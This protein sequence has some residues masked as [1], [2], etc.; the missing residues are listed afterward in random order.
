MPKQN[1]T[2]KIKKISSGN[3]KSL[4]KKSASGKTSTTILTHTKKEE[5]IHDLKAKQIEIDIQKQELLQQRDLLEISRDKYADLYD[6][7]PVG[8]LTLDDRG[9]ITEANLTA[10]AMLGVERRFL[11]KIPFINFLQTSGMKRF[12]DTL[13]SCR[14]HNSRMFDEF[15]IN[16][17]KNGSLEVQITALPVVDYS[18]KKVT[19]RLS[20]LDIAEKKKAQVE[21]TESEERFRLMADAAP[22]MIWM[23]D[24]NKK[25]VYLNK[26]ST[27][28]YGKSLYYLKSEGWYQQTHP[29]D[30]DKFEKAFSEASEFNTSRSFEVRRKNKEG[31]YR[32][33]FNSVNPRYLANGTFEGYAG[34]GF[35]ITDR[36][37]IQEEIET[38]LKEKEILLTEV[39][40]RVKN[41]LQIISSILS[42][43]TYYLG[44]KSIKEILSACR[45]RVSSMSLLHEQLYHTKDFLNINFKSY[46]MLLIEEL[47]S[48]YKNPSSNIDF[49]LDI[50]DIKLDIDISVNLGLI[51]NE[52]ITNSLK[53]A[54]NDKKNGEINVSIKHGDKDEMILKVSDNGVGLP[55]NFNIHNL[56]SLGLEIVS[57]LAEQLNGEF[58][59]N[60]NR[61]GL[62]F[63][64]IIHSDNFNS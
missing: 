42:L 19:Y 57:S 1:N 52:L 61:E 31:E 29:E 47:L 18:S 26:S 28:F 22:A 39:H 8:F 53:Y 4:K 44:N 16:N 64:L 5:L 58:Q 11:I 49:K 34:I 13:R 23:T 7:A 41:N 14:N 40:H 48:T 15:V 56:K 10:S 33:I 25:V 59:I 9:V 43:Q 12:L 30:I 50:D 51:L 38:S 17:R 45:T 62:E 35:D 37:K 63:Q 60:N 32:W 3:G 2:K 21:L 36:K 6:F 54:F 20:L 55:E 46:I 27:E 24:E